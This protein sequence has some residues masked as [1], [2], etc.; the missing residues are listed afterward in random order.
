MGKKTLIDTLIVS[1]GQAGIATSERLSRNAV[2]HLMLERDRIAERWR[3]GGGIRW[4]PMALTGTTASST[5]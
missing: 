5:I 4:W 3:Q 1:A 2:P